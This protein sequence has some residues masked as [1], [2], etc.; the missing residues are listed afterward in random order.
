[1]KSMKPLRSVISAI[2]FACVTL[3]AGFSNSAETFDKK[4]WLADLDQ[5]HDAMAR[6]YANLEWAVFTREASLADLFESTKSRIQSASNDADARAAF[7][8]FA[9][10]LGD[11][12]LLFVWPHAKT[13]NLNV[14][15]NRCRS[16]GYDGASRAGVLVA[17]AP[18]YHAIETPQSRDFPA[19]FIMSGQTKVGVVKIGVFMPQGFPA[20]C[21]AAIKALALPAGRPC[22][23]T[24]SSTVDAW[25]TSHLTDELAEQIRTLQAA[26]AQMLLIDIADNGGGT[27]WAETVARMVTPIRLKSERVDFV[28]SSE[29]ADAF[30]KDE[31]A[32]RRF[33]KGANANDRTLL[34][35]LADQIDAKRRV[36]LIPCSSEPLWRGEHPACSWLGEG[37]YG[38]GY[39]A[40]A[41]PAALAG[42]PWASLV[43][44]PMEVT[45]HEGVW[46]GPLIVLINRNTGSAASEFAAVLKDNHAALL[47]GEPADGGCGHTLNGAP[48]KLKHS[49]AIFEM[50]DCARF[51]AD[52]SNEITGVE[53]DTLIGFTGTDGPHAR[54]QR[55]IEKL[56]DAVAAIRAMTRTV[57]PLH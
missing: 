48:I 19:G 37:F 23:D 22:D 24:C 29:W 40:E 7:D 43:F 30:A 42:K 9:R 57:L 36:A 56:P 3:P 51:R 17:D 28:R 52:G 41:D 34:L 5:V 6:Q 26:G 10:K 32:L 13:Q 25:V 50:P 21:E 53:P 35:R 1:M 55:F 44:T 14:P 16:L 49:G 2:A 15:E 8:R 4:A 27:E 20:L 31:A 33:A 18:G 12:H 39:L 46:R 38:S 45:Y 54:A 11:G 47:L